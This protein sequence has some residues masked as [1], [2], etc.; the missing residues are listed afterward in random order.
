MRRQMVVL[1]LL[2]ALLTTIPAG[3]H[4]GSPRAG[5][6]GC[7]SWYGKGH[8]GQKTASGEHFSRGRLTAAHRTLPLGTMVMVT[9]LRTRQDVIVRINDRGPYGRAPRC[10]IDLSEAAAKHI[11]VVQRGVERVRV[12][13]VENVS[14]HRPG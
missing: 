3:A 13:V 12:V 10:I 14:R 6:V 11:G 2:S 5:Q 1:G 4:A 9:N 8:H 7:A